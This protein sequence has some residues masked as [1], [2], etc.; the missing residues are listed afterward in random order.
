[1]VFMRMGA[2][3]GMSDCAARDTSK[4]FG[5]ISMDDVTRALSQADDDGDEKDFGANGPNPR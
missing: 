2:L 5:I 3:P 1:M 4:L